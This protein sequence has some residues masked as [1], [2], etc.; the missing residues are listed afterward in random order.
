MVD[1]SGE[2]RC[3]WASSGREAEEMARDLFYHVAL[4]QE[5]P[6]DMHG[7]EL[8]AVLRKIH[9]ETE[10]ILLGEAPEDEIER[11]NFEGD[12]F[13]Y[14]PTF[15][16]YE[17]LIATIRR[18]L[19]RQRREVDRRNRA[20]YEL[21]G[22]LAHEIRSP[23]SAIM[24]SSNLLYE[25][26]VPQETGQ[27]GGNKDAIP[28][29][30]QNVLTSASRID[31]WVEE[32]L[33]LAKLRCGTFT[34]KPVEIDSRA[35]LDEAMDLVLPDLRN[36]GQ[37]VARDAADYLPPVTADRGA[38]VQSLVYLLE[39]A[40][41]FTPSDASVRL[42]AWPEQDHLKIEIIDG[43][44]PISAYLL[45]RMSNPFL[46]VEADRVYMSRLGIGF[47]LAAYLLAAHD[48]R[49]WIERRE[50]GNAFCLLLPGAGLVYNR[51]P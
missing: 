17:S 37:S 45:A 3:D 22:S 32:L 7:Y 26:L 27:P 4:V 33:D 13:D 25:E 1:V 28:R 24:V 11:E 42:N 46:I 12:V 30:V 49:L 14:L 41:R 34:L 40:S 51:K 15:A 47:A 2:F 50:H 8:A 29:L 38:M 36:R 39:N 43:A 19:R 31:N 5:Q 20:G 10:V 48:G 35:L 21:Y 44:P 6:P 9:I 16:D 23:L 18:A